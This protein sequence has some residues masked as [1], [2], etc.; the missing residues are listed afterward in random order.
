MDAIERENV[1]ENERTRERERERE[2]RSI[3]E[4]LKKFSECI[5]SRRKRM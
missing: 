2:E 5:T 3:L 1:G 4:N